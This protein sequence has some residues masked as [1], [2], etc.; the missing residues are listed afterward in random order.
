MVDSYQ[1]GH[2]TIA[3]WR[4][5]GVHFFF[6]CALFNMLT[7]IKRSVIFSGHWRLIGVCIFFFFCVLFNMLT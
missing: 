7:R 4:L 1:I 6:S 3:Y 2:G 5:I